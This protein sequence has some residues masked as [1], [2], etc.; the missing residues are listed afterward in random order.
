MS[1]PSGVL[2]EKCGTEYCKFLLLQLSFHEGEKEEEEIVE[3]D[4][5][6]DDFLW[7]RQS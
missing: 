7:R 1:S 2:H 6:S 3:F 4:I 5:L